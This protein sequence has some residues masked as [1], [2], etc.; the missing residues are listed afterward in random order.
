MKFIVDDKIPYIQGALEPFGEVVYLPGAM[1]TAEIVNNADAIITRT[2][3]AC[4]RQLLRG[5]TVKYIATATIGFDHI[6][7]TY[8]EQAGI[9]WSNAPGCNSKSVEQYLLST[10]F[11]L[12]RN[13]NFSLRNISIGIVGV[14]HVGSKVAS[15]C[16]LLG[17]R[18]LLNDPP[19]ERHE[20]ADQFVSLKEI[21]QEADIISLHVPL[22]LVGRDATFHLAD[23]S[24]F[25]TLG[26]SPIL[27]NTCRGEVV[28]SIS[29]KSALA[30]ESISGLVL[31]CW[32]NEPD[33][34]LDLLEQCDLG[35]SHIAG[36][37]KDGKANGTTMSIRAISRFFGLGIDDWEPKHIEAPIRS[38]IKLDGHGKDE[39]RIIDEAVLGTYDVRKDDLTL[40]NT[41]Q[42]FEKHRGEYP[43]RREFPAY[44]ILPE[45]MSS[46]TVEK[47]KILGFNIEKNSEP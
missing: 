43:V 41:P 37:S 44:S 14:G 16:D 6:D 27:I 5:S 2:R 34:D 22:N 15:V 18:V 46:S 28:D 12:A 36:Y 33:I 20:G 45:N 47:L 17:M 31:D 7:T 9:E 38:H 42:D 19:R 10:L 13:N 25:Q 29:A 40:R 39:E 3:T 24:F 30:S 23:A 35:T 26:Q 4:N 1:T 8:C 21:K 11:V 32:E